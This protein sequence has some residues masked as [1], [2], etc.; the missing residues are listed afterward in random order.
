VYLGREF[1]GLGYYHRPG[2]CD[3]PKLLRAVAILTKNDQSLDNYLS[4]RSL[5]SVWDVN[6]RSELGAICKSFSRYAV[7]R[8]TVRSL[9]SLVSEYDEKSPEYLNLQQLWPIVDK[10]RKVGFIPI[11]EFLDGIEGYL[12][13]G[14]P[15]HYKRV[16][17]GTSP[18]IYE[19]AKDYNRLLT[20]ILDSDRYPY[21]IKSLKKLNWYE[22]QVRLNWRGYTLFVTEE[23]CNI[24]RCHA[25]DYCIKYL[26][27]QLHYIPASAFKPFSLRREYVFESVYQDMKV[28]EP[29]VEE[30]VPEKTRFIRGD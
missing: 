27:S 24:A 30:V 26:G 11:K 9:N 22:I 3:P 6:S 16:D 17:Y 19:V 23:D 18:T 21:D 29:L 4:M 2:R 13:S 14:L 7:G 28:P 12:Y 20:K 8:S 1:G 10:L 15:S 5:G 25:F